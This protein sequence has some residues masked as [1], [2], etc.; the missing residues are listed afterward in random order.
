MPRP[1]THETLSSTHSCMTSSYMNEFN[2]QGRPLLLHWED[3]TLLHYLRSGK[4]LPGS[5]NK[6]CK[7]VMKLA[8]HYILDQDT[9][10]YLVDTNDL[11]NRVKVPKPEERFDLIKATHLLGHFKNQTTF[12]RLREKCFWKALC[13]I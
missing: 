9:L 11:E 7:R 6:Q 4:Y 2:E 1:Q 10:W 13:G 5:S 8:D 3:S 12:N